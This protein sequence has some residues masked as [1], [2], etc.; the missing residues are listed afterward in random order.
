MDSTLK[1][2][3]IGMRV[4]VF[5][6]CTKDTLL[7]F[8]YGVYEADEVPPEGIF[9]PSGPMSTLEMPL[10]K[11][12]LDDGLIIWGCE[13]WWCPEAEVQA[14]AQGREVIRP[15]IESQRKKN[16]EA[17]EKACHDL[18]EIEENLP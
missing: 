7:L 6:S 16:L 13:A 10:P 3:T 4:G 9:G 5:H 2:A 15:K 11:L 14:M 18:D 8:G 12:R 1:A 17:W